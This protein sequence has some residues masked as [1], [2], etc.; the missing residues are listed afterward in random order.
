MT[1][2]LMS[3]DTVSF[4][5]REGLERSVLIGHSMGGKTAMSV[6]LRHPEMV[7]KLVVV[8]VSPRTSVGKGEVE[9][10]VRVLR[11]LDVSVLRSR[12]EAD[13]RLREQIPVGPDDDGVAQRSFLSDGVY[14]NRLHKKWK[15]HIS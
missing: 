6:A 3:R 7:E 5:Q 2:D 1:Y 11:Q 15:R 8:D 9:D 12:S 14:L 13:F 4:L 10:L